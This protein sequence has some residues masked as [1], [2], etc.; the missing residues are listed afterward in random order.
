ML[1]MGVVLL[2]GIAPILVPVAGLIYVA[3]RRERA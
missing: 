2:W 1:T 3:L